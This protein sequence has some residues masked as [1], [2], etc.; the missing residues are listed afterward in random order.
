MMNKLSK[1]SVY[2][3]FREFRLEMRHAWG[4]GSGSVAD[5]AANGVRRG[6]HHDADVYEGRCADFSGEV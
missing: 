5:V 2:V 4:T 3:E 6:T 1:R